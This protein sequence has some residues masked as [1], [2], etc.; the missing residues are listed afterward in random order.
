MMQF[1]NIICN[2]S[3]Y[4]SE[5]KCGTTA[6]MERYIIQGQDQVTNFIGRSGKGS[7]IVIN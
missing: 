2:I 4:F 3:R 7:A 1:N 6:G 5:Q